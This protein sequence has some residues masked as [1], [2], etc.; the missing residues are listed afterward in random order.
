MPLKRYL[1]SIRFSQEEW[2]SIT[3]AAPPNRMSP[4]EFVREAAVRVAGEENGFPD[5]QLTPEL[6]ELIKTTF[7]GVHV[8]AYLKRE[9]LDGADEKNGS[10]EPSATLKPSIWRCFPRPAPIERGPIELAAFSPARL[11]WRPILTECCHPF[12]AKVSKRVAALHGI[13]RAPQHIKSNHQ[14]TIGKEK[15]RTNG[16]LTTCKTFLWQWIALAML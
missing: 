7:R 13:R 10:R 1:H 12:Y 6:I 11:Q 15:W 3:S 5:G 14:A 8:L 2:E 9:Q 4:G 16:L